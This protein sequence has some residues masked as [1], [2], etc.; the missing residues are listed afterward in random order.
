M[1]F[2]IVTSLIS[3]AS[4]AI[5]CAISILFFAWVYSASPSNELATD[6]KTDMTWGQGN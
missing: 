3:A 1:R 4:I 5:I 6:L 2:A